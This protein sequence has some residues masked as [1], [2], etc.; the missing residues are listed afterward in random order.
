[1]NSEALRSA[2]GRLAGNYRWTW[3][4]STRSLFDELPGHD[5]KTHPA[6]LVSALDHDTLEDLSGRDEFASRVAVELEELDALL[7]ERQQPL[8]AYCSPEFGLT[9]LLPQYAGGL[10]VLAG[11]H[12][13]SA[14]DLGLRLVGVGLFY[15]EGVFRQVIE[16]GE[17]HEVYQRVEPES[18]GAIDTGIIVHVPFPDRMVEARVWRIDVGRVPLLLLDT[19]IPGNSDRDRRI[20]DR[21]YAGDRSHRLEQEMVLGVGGARALDAMGWEIKAHHLNEGHAGFIVLELIDPLIGEHGLERA[22][23]LVRAGLAFTTHTPVPAGIDRFAAD[24]IRP[25][26]EIWADRWAIPVEELW[27]L[28]QDP[29]NGGQFNMAALCLRTSRMANGVSRLHGQ[30]SRKLFAGVGIG[31]DIG[32]VTNGVHARTWTARHT[33]DL[34]DE[35]LGRGWAGGDQEAWA[36]AG[37][38]SSSDLRSM[39]RL[40]SESLGRLAAQRARAS[41]DPD[42]LIVGFARRFAPY[43][44]ATLLLQRPDLLEKLIEDEAR[45]VHFVFSGKAHPSDA[46]GKGLV[47]DVVRAAA[48]PRTGTHFTFIP[49]YDMDVARELVQGCDIWLNNPIRP[50]EASGTSG[51]KAVLN[52][53]LNC[54]ILDG[55]WAEMFDGRNGWAIEAVDEGPPEVRDALEAERALRTL[56]AIRDLY[57]DRRSDFDARMVHAWSTLGPQITASRMVSEY[58]ETIYR[59]LL[60]SMAT[61]G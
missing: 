56:I 11:D 10:G 47:A 37:E 43:K 42:A 32:H 6:A 20:T 16:N 14:S 49:D 60:E 12:L 35:V 5:E 36:R 38:I 21:L 50:R 30:V 24:T 8:V 19:D 18:V 29:D 53:G 48:S 61:H 58:D 27:A 2:L 34:F 31:D 39:R 26:L 7:A 40:S 55:W 17:Q 4:A 25:Y 45:P 1:L 51:E 22:V 15:G 59:P 13:K 52:G 44:R 46:T 54:S 9:A 23:E 28:G 3:S 41:I 57:H 33:Q